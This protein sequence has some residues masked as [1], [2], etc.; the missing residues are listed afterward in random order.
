VR[1]GE[2][3]G[4][5]GWNEW[6]GHP[7]RVQ[8]IPRSHDTDAARRLWKVSEQL[9]AVTYHIGAHGG[10]AGVINEAYETPG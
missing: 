6:T 4:P 5:G 1:G 7:E 9:T 10:P 3:F 2:Y 8:S